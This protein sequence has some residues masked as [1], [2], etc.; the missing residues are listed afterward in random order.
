MSDQIWVC[1]DGKEILVSEMEDNH[2]IN[3]WRVFTKK[4]E[5]ILTRIDQGLYSIAMLEKL[6]NI[7]KRLGI[8]IPEMIKRGMHE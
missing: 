7:E 5:K 3:A 1:K 6:I 8:I 4:K 2:L